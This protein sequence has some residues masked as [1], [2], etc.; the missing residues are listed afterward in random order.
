MNW[1]RVDLAA[2][3]FADDRPRHLPSPLREH[4]KPYSRPSPHPLPGQST[5]RVIAPAARASA[6]AALARVPDALDLGC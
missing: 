1:G 4:P 6:F 3:T 2:P 5:P